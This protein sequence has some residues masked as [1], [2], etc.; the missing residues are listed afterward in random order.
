M[1]KI[2]WFWES[3]RSALNARW[4][5]RKA[6]KVGPRVRLRGRPVVINH[7]RMVIGDRVQLLSTVATLELVT[8]RGGTLEIGERSLVNLAARSSPRG[9]C[10]SV[11]IATSAR[12]R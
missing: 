1:R 9:L 10:R 2:R 3:G 11:A 7:G 12:T 6:D 4:A 5:L 8:E